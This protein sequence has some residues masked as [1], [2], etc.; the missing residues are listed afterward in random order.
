[1]NRGIETRIRALLNAARRRRLLVV[2][3]VMLDQFLWG[4]VRR[5]SPEAPVPVVEFRRESFMAGGAAN[6]A[7]NLTAL[8]CGAR[9]FGV[10]GE[11]PAAAHLLEILGRDGVDCSGML[12]IADRPTAL[13]TRVIA[14][15]QHVVRIDRER[16]GPLSEGDAERL[17]DSIRGALPGA[18]A[19]LVGDYAK[20]VV[21]QG[22]LDALVSECRRAGVWLSADPKPSNGLV[23]EGF[24]LV[25]P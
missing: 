17:L 15:H 14:H 25:T 21:S 6:V 24:S 19:V 23:L 3:D 2:G 13:K 7:R 5:I 4:D 12:T 8:G 16:R 1:M 22:L 9:L 20:G 10:V 11:D 18:D